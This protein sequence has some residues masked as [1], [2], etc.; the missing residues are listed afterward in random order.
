M[1]ALVCCPAGVHAGM[2][3]VVCVS[4]CVSVCVVRFPRGC[5][6]VHWWVCVRVCVVWVHV[7]LGLCAC[8]GRVCACV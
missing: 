3:G 1:P 8:V 7:L 5:V 4:V 6:F 2:C